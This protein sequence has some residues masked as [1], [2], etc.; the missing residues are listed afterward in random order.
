MTDQLEHFQSSRTGN[1]IPGLNLLDLV[2]PDA[3]KSIK[4]TS[5]ADR[6]AMPFFVRADEKT[7]PKGDTNT[8]DAP[9]GKEAPGPSDA[10]KVN[11]APKTQDAPKP[12]Q[13][14]APAGGNTDIVFLHFNDMH[15]TGI[16]NGDVAAMTETMKERIEQAN[17]EGK[18]VVVVFGGDEAG[19]N[20][21]ASNGGSGR[22]ENQVLK[23]MKELIGQDIFQVIGNHAADGAKDVSHLVDVAK[24]TNAK[25]AVSNVE[26]TGASAT[27][28]GP[29]QNFERFQVAKAKGPN[30]TTTDVG[31][32]GL[33]TVE[34]TS[35]ASGVRLKYETLV[36]LNAAEIANTSKI[37]DKAIADNKTDPASALPAFDS[38]ANKGKKDPLA[39]F[40]NMTAEELKARALEFNTFLN[41]ADKD[42]F[43]FSEGSK[44]TYND[45]YI[46]AAWDTVKEMKAQGI[47]KI[48]IASHLGLAVDLVV[49]KH[50]PDVS[51]VIG[52]HSH[53]AVAVPNAVKNDRTG[54]EVAVVQAGCKAQFLGETQ[55]SYKGEKGGQEYEVKGALHKIEDI[56]KNKKPGELSEKMQ[57]YVDTL[58]QNGDPLKPLLKKTIDDIAKSPEFGTKA[59]APLVAAGN[60][61]DANLR[62]GESCLG[63]LTADSLRCALNEYQLKQSTPGGLP[64]PMLN[65]FLNHMGGIRNG[66]DAGAVIDGVKLSDIFCTGNKG[67]EL[68]V[69]TMTPKMLKDVLEF[70]VADFPEPGKSATHDYNGNFLTPSGIKVEYDSNEQQGMKYVKASDDKDAAIER[71]GKRITKISV[72]NPETDKYEL[73][74]DAA[75]MTDKQLAESTRKLTIGTRAHAI[76]KWAKSGVFS[77]LERY[78]EFK[79]AK[80]AALKQLRDNGNANPN[81]K[82]VHELAGFKLFGVDGQVK[83]TADGGWVSTIEITQPEALGKYLNGD[84]KVA[85]DILF[86]KGPGGKVELKPGKVGGLDGRFVDVSAPPKSVVK[87]VTTAPTAAD[88]TL[89]KAQPELVK[90][91]VYVDEPRHEKAPEQTVKDK[92][93][94]SV[95][96]ELTIV[97]DSTQ[98]PAK[99]ASSDTKSGELLEREKVERAARQVETRPLVRKPS[100]AN[101]DHLFPGSGLQVVNG[102]GKTVTVKGIRQPLGQ[103]D[104]SYLVQGENGLVVDAELTKSVKERVSQNETLKEQ[105]KEPT[106]AVKAL[107]N[108]AQASQDVGAS[109]GSETTGKLIDYRALAETAKKALGPTATIDGTM[110]RF[111]SEAGIPM[112]VK[113]K[114]ETGKKADVRSLGEGDLTDEKM[115]KFVQEMKIEDR[116]IKAQLEKAMKDLLNNPGEAKDF[117]TCQKLLAD[118][119]RAGQLGKVTDEL[120]EV[121]KSYGIEFEN[122]KPKFEN[123]QLVLRPKTT[124]G[125][126]NKVH[127]GPGAFEKCKGKAV[128]IM[129]LALAVAAPSENRPQIVAPRH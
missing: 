31:I 25:F 68:V 98:G 47:E 83:P 40:R 114:P 95:L 100:G 36:G 21:V 115:A 92:P 77:D 90:V 37:L 74:W 41:R 108:F 13:P 112:V 124:E 42:K 23:K 58:R 33:T 86:E 110:V 127:S 128:P 6:D 11:E 27:A 71:P 51:L 105:L 75:T 78:P 102:E 79:A 46:H 70:G 118:K 28:L 72:L 80:E 109:S 18:F 44:F 123:N 87:P 60:Y 24:Q 43:S 119:I 54:K 30:N 84:T 39:K 96:P 48:V 122:G 113:F 20:T 69:S 16:L 62:K 52:A 8:P 57:A 103:G 81:P 1:D 14:G 125:T 116:E 7:E 49:A 126:D 89:K 5:I 101:I 106:K 111:Q 32:I 91:A 17:K 34:Y 88:S 120:R 2:K 73:I 3:Y 94:S 45:A 38:E 104:V 50:V 61:S 93:A 82:Q 12:A 66:I 15:S 121:F 22:V 29:N 56:R 9:K 99:P 64:R 55:V 26:F 76:E 107:H 10:P 117:E 4:P 19:G 129:M 67:G 85:P 63:N 65:G 59:D 97:G 35:E 53:D